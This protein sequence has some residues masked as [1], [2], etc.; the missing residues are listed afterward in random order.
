MNLFREFLFDT[1]DRIA[2]YQ[3]KEK[4]YVTRDVFIAEK[5][6]TFRTIATVSKNAGDS[7][8][9]YAIL[10]A[11]KSLETKAHKA[12][13]ITDGWYV[14]PPKPRI[15]YDPIIAWQGEY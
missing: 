4:Y 6:E 13:S 8:L 9:Y 5:W 1:K 7:S 11:A 3:D 14:S 2:I 10:A 15:E 12:I